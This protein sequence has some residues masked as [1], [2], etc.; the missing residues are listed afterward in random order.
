M[1]QKSKDISQKSLLQEIEDAKSVMENEASAIHL[2]SQRLNEEFINALDILFSNDKKGYNY[3]NRKIWSFSKK[4][5][6][7]PFVV[8]EHLQ[9]LCIPRK[10][11]TEIWVFIKRMIL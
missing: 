3:R 11:F 10:L 8:Q 6:L 7:P 9:R 1:I 5:L 4:R 2:C